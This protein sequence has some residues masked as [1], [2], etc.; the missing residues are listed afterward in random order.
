MA[1]GL[2]HLITNGTLLFYLSAQAAGLE[3]RERGSGSEK[4]NRN[5]NEKESGVASGRI[6]LL[7]P[8]NLHRQ[9]ITVNIC[10]RPKAYHKLSIFVHPG[11]CSWPEAYLLPGQKYRIQALYGIC[12][13]PKGYLFLI[14]QTT[15]R[16]S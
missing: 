4:E 3:Q 12:T 2:P 9:I 13:S 5:E 16:N 6:S 10:I 14:P 11:K 8:A 7:Q 1:F 15:N